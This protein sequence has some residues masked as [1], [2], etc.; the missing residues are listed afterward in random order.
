M[1]IFMEI[2]I[3]V[4]S[5]W[6]KAISIENLIPSN[7]WEMSNKIEQSESNYDLKY[8]FYQFLVSADRENS[9]IRKCIKYWERLVQDEHENEFEFQA[10][11]LLENCIEIWG[12]VKKRNYQYKIRNFNNRG[13]INSR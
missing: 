5:Q 9:L 10:N 7:Y 2:N 12:E 6:N 3:A 1:I 13:A 8:E 11:S 4:K